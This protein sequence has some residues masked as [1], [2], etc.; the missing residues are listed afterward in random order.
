M[1]IR[2]E[3]DEF[4]FANTAGPY[5]NYRWLLVRIGNVPYGVYRSVSSFDNDKWVDDYLIEQMQYEV[6]RLLK[7]SLI[8]GEPITICDGEAR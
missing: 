3:L 7:N 8:L 6:A 4:K 5:G 2:L 1:K